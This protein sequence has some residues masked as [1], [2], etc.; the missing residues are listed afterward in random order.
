MKKVMVA[1]AILAM[2]S[3]AG[4]VSFDKEGTV[5]E[6]TYGYNFLSSRALV[7]D[8]SFEDGTCAGGSAWTCDADNGCD[9]IADLVP[10]GLWNYDGIHV[11]WL[12]GFCGG[13]ATCY[14]TIC[15]TITV[16][17]AIS[18]YWMG[19][20]NDAVQYNYITV[21]GDEVWGYVL[22]LSD[23]LLDYQQLSVDTSAYAGGTYEVCFGVDNTANCAGNLGDNLFVDYVETGLVAN[24][25]MSFSSVKALY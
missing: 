7:N 16:G 10:L 1:L 18:F 11:A 2:A 22:Q 3:V 8:G 4:A 25:E 23:H 9:W 24:E 14:S 13:L 12:G 20:V 6:G 5:L 15:Q 21:N 17:D 19:Y